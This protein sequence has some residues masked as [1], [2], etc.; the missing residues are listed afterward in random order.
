L[1]INGYGGEGKQ[2]EEYQ[3]EYRREIANE[4]FHII[5]N[6][7]KLI[8]TIQ[9]DPNIKDKETAIAFSAIQTSTNLFLKVLGK[10][11]EQI[12][13]LNERISILEKKVNKE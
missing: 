7:P 10:Y 1:E 12:N 6:L 8:E 9:K 5:R 3:R 2:M 11:D 13:N 4:S